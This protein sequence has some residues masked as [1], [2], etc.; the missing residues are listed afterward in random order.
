M[1]NQLRIY[2]IFPETAQAFH[3][4]F[5]DHAARIMGRHGFRIQAMWE[6]GEGETLVFVYL[7]A[8]ESEGEMQERWASFMAD[9][10][11]IEIKKTTKEQPMVGGID[12]MVLR[13]TAYSTAIGGAA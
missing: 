6:T 4:R 3:D 2:K 12:E 5:R 9:E 10:E 1:I 11:W 13:P 7:L 8:W